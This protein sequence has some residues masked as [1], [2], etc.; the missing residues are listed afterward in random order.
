MRCGIPTLRVG[1]RAGARSL[2]AT[3]QHNTN[4]H[5]NNSNVAAWANE[6]VRALSRLR[7][8]GD[9]AHDEAA[10]ASPHPLR[11]EGVLVLVPPGQ[12]R[13]ALAAQEL[14][15]GDVVRPPLVPRAVLL[16]GWPR[17]IHT[18]GL[19]PPTGMRQRHVL[20]APPARG[21]RHHR[22]GPRRRRHGD[23]EVPQPEVQAVLG[24]ARL[25]AAG[26]EPPLRGHDVFGHLL[27]GELQRGALQATAGLSGVD[28]GGHCRPTAFLLTLALLKAPSFSDRCD[29]DTEGGLAA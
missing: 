1:K 21:R 17:G 13:H 22:G 18:T 11:G 26:V 29:D 28:H 14:A 5:I 24:G 23:V 10:W 4:N 2:T 27:N 3:Q 20:D 7:G 19:A 25:V 15:A 8:H 6:P 9:V 16:V 12:H